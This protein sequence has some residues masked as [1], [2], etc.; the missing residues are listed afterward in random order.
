MSVSEEAPDHA[1]VDQIPAGPVPWRDRWPDWVL[2]RRA[3]QAR[4]ARWAS[5]DAARQAAADAVQARWVAEGQRLERAVA[6]VIRQH[7]EWQAFGD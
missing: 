2:T 6:Q 5:E 4:I 1:F 3:R 7:P